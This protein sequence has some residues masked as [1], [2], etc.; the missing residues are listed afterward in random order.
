MKYKKRTREE[1]LISICLAE[2]IKL[3]TVFSGNWLSGLNET[4]YWESAQITHQK[5]ATLIEVLAKDGLVSK[6]YAA[7]L[8]SGTQ[9]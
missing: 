2:R 3:E 9:R 7:E 6:R 5:A 1:V 8:D 4:N